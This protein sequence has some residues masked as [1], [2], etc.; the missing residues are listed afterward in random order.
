MGNPRTDWMF[1]SEVEPGL[2]GRQIRYPR[3]RVMGGCSS[4]S[5]MI[6]MRGQAQDYNGWEALGNGGWSWADVL[7]AFKQHEDHYLAGEAGSSLFNELHGNGGEW[8][9]E[10]QRVSWR[11]LDAWRRA[12]AQSGIAPVDD[13]NGGSN[14]GCGY[15]EVNQNGVVRLNAAQAF[16]APVRRRPNLTIVSSAV[17]S[18]LLFTGSSAVD[19]RPQVSGLIYRRGGEFVD[20]SIDLSR[21]GEVVLAAG[22]IGTPQILERSGI[23]RTDVL[24][25]LGIPVRCAERGVGENLQ[26]HLQLR[27]VFKVFGVPSLNR[28]ANSWF[29]KVR[30]SLQ[31]A[32]FKTGAMAAA[33]GQLGAFARSDATRLRSVICS[34]LVEVRLIFAAETCLLPRLSLLTICR[35]LRI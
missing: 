1:N 13:F 30:M 4:I 26:D 33:P 5:G 24:D 21:R 16:V 27:T 19:G 18:E 23:G 29:G 17:V 7:P 28:T 15:F 31:Y 11:I 2:N 9:V 8:R 22:A 10:K 25:S 12:A 20:V 3:G 34:R 6:Y 35:T 14:F 32:L